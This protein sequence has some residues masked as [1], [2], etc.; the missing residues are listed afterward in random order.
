MPNA[1]PLEMGAISQGAE[2]CVESPVSTGV[3][4]GSAALDSFVSFPRR[5]ATLPTAAAAKPSSI[6]A[7]RCDSNAD[8]SC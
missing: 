5:R 8:C 6:M 1:A 7:D 4:L 2:G 3:H